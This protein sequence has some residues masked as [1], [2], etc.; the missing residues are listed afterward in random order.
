MKQRNTKF[1]IEIY[2]YLLNKGEG[3]EYDDSIC[4]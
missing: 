4:K 1:F 3:Y 2:I